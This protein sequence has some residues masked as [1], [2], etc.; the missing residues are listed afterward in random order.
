MYLGVGQDL[1][2]R[3]YNYCNGSHL[4]PLVQW[5]LAW[6]WEILASTRRFQTLEA[7]KD[8]EKRELDRTDYSWNQQR[9]WADHWTSKADITLFPASFHSDWTDV[10]MF[11]SKQLRLFKA[12]Y[13]ADRRRKGAKVP[14]IRI[15]KSWPSRST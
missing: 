12:W 7:A 4:K 10:A 6:G 2:N 13:N 5:H 8:F 14:I 15:A 3:L 9:N 11:R 1:R